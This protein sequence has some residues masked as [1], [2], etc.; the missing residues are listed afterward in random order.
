MIKIVIP[1]KFEKLKY[2]GASEIIF[3]TPV[4]CLMLVY[5]SFHYVVNLFMIRNVSVV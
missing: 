2:D 1:N 5:N 4:K 3:F